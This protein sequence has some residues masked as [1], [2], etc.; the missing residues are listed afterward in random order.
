M[1]KIL[2]FA[3]AFLLPCLSMAQ[4]DGQAKYEVVSYILN[5]NLLSF[6][7][8]YM[9]AQREE[10]PQ[11]Y[12]FASRPDSVVLYDLETFRE[13][14]M[15]GKDYRSAY[16]KQINNQYKK[17]IAFWKSRDRAKEK[18]ILL[19]GMDK[20]ALFYNAK[21]INKAEYPGS[22][23]LIEGLIKSSSVIWDTQKIT[24]EHGVRILPL[25]PA[26]TA[27]FHHQGAGF[28][29]L[30]DVIMD[31]SQTRSAVLMHWFCGDECGACYLLLLGK[32][33][34]QWHYRQIRMLW[35]S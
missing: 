33:N 10:E 30:S 24:G 26:N 18:I 1:N 15:A 12:G 28:I 4:S 35:E 22:E 17:E 32:E 19:E 3:A 5:G 29:Q 20:R 23:N 21:Y 7:Y 9:F 34:G 13:K 25:T 6:D 16:Q 31:E 11:E 2:F 27:A 8:D 14:P